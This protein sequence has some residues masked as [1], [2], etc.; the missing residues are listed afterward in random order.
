VSAVAL[1]AHHSASGTGS[2]TTIAD[3][4]AI[5]VDAG[6]LAYAITMANGVVA[7]TDPTGFAMI[8]TVWNT[9]NKLDGEFSVASAAGSVDPQWTWSFQVPSTWFASA[10]ALNPQRAT[11]LGFLVQPSSTML[12]GS[13]IAPAVQVVA[14][15]DQGRTVIGFTGPV[16]VA[17]A[18]DGSPLQNARLSG[19]AV[20]IPA[21]GVA[22][23]A[24][25]SIDQ[26][27]M[28]YTLQVTANGLTG[29]TSN[30]FNVTVP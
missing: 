19:T 26:V 13:K 10:V 16:T 12:P 6:A 30:S 29:V 3:P 24:D 11:H 28:G 14:L 8:T 21:N 1:A 4:G 20:K 9:T 22:T 17:M 18:H 2:T 7:V 25:L 5:P 23:F 27:G 15:D